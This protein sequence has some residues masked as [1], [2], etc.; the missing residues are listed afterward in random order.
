M[1]SISEE[2]IK[3][4]GKHCSLIII[5][6]FL[7]YFRKSNNN[8]GYRHLHFPGHPVV[9]SEDVVAEAVRDGGYYYDNVQRSM[10][11]NPNAQLPLYSSAVKGSN[12][13]K[14]LLATGSN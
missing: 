7:N 6:Y 11:Y 10:G 4:T 3:I 12:L 5:Q 2:R 1:F 14:Q 9:G 13:E 8:C